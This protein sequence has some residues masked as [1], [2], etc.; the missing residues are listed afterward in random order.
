M[1]RRLFSRLFLSGAATS[2]TTVMAQRAASPVPD[3]KTGKPAEY[4]FLVTENYIA[5]LDPANLEPTNAGLVAYRASDSAGLARLGSRVTVADE[6]L[7]ATEFPHLELPQPIAGIPELTE[8]QPLAEGESITLVFHVPETQDRPREDSGFLTIPGIAGASATSPAL[9][10]GVFT[11]TIEATTADPPCLSGSEKLKSARIKF[12]VQTWFGTNRLFSTYLTMKS[13]TRYLHGEISLLFG[14]KTIKWCVSFSA[15]VAT[16]VNNLISII[17]KG[18]DF[19]GYPQSAATLS[20]I[21]NTLVS[22]LRRAVPGI[23]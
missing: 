17:A 1:N 20:N 11:I 3:D 7:E 6:S 4:V 15:I 2:A 10:I 12:D 13:S 14:L 19:V 16:L 5:R 18:L 8:I 23:I 21:A 22:A 9:K